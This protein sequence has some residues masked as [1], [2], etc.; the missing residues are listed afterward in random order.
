[1]THAHR[2]TTAM[3]KGLTA[4][5][6]HFRTARME[7]TFPVGTR[8]DGAC[9]GHYG[10]S[11]ISKTKHLAAALAVVV[12]LGSAVGCDTSPPGGQKTERWVTTENTN[13]P[14]NWDKVN[15][16]YKQAQGPEDL[17]RRVNEIYEGDEIISISVKDVDD[18]NQVVTGFFDK[19]Q[20][21]SVDDGEKIFTIQRQITGEGQAQ[22][23]T[24]G[25]GPY[26]GYH[27]PFFS[28]VSGMVVG[29][30][31]ANAL[32]PGYRPIYVQGYTTPPSRTDALAQSRS[33]YRAQNPSQFQRSKSGRTYNAPSSK[34]RPVGRTGGGG[35][36]GGGRF[37]LARA[38]RTVRPPR[39]AA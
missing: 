9:R 32:T 16:A 33:A 12:G 27:S 26:Y 2:Q 29:S 18:K 34:S 23:Q 11:M 37:G 21:G 22:V 5:E 10:S 6:Y 30:M 15:E 20:N 17:E 4:T 14:L 19:N 13:V 7:R 3:A 36:V 35:R 31:L 24:V 1:V 8:L 25:Y 38:G 28:V 39:L